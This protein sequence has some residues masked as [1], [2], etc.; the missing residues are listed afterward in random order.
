VK[1]LV[2]ECCDAGVVTALRAAGHDVVYV[3]EI[4]RGATDD[5]VLIYS[6]DEERLL[7]TEDKDF[8]ELV[9]R[10]RLPAY[11]V[12]LLRF[13]PNETPLKIA[14]LL[15]LLAASADPLPGS[16][17]VLDAVKARVRPLLII[18]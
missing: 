9:Y 5:D 7:L 4:L 1:L 15:T 8:G 3:M 12:I 18:P 16:F 10:L 2:D 17:V 13:E 14:R 11:G 6:Y